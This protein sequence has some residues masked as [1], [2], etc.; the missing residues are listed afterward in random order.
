MSSTELYGGYTA[1]GV[2]RYSALQIPSSSTTY[3]FVAGGTSRSDYSGYP[4]RVTKAGALYA[5]NAY[6]KGEITATS[7]SFT[8]TITASSGSKFGD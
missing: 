6:I 2:T 4:F 5:T 3:V 8:G 1:N 7:G